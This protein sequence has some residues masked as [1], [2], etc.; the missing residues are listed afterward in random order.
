MLSIAKNR[1]FC[2]CGVKTQIVS[3]SDSQEKC[4]ALDPNILYS[5]GV[6]PL[7]SATILHYKVS[8][9]EM[10]RSFCAG[11]HC[12]ERCIVSMDCLHCAFEARKTRRTQVAEEENSYV[13]IIG[14]TL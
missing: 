4:L 12:Y 10:H 8:G 5:P 14:G 11:K 9:S 6:I 13:V 7:T 2:S 1:V 3:I